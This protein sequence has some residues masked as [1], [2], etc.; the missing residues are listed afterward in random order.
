MPLRPGSNLTNV[1]LP[2]KNASAAFL[3]AGE[4]LGRAFVA[5][6]LPEQ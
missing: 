3:E 1:L 2:P 6:G 4:R 5:A